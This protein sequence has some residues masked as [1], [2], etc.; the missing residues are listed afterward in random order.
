MQIE[1]IN[2]GPRDSY[3]LRAVEGATGAKL[4]L[5]LVYWQPGGTGVPDKVFVADF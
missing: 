1:R 5:L 3:L 4:R 2:S